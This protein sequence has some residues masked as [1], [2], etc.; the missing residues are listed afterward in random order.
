MNV[1]H[2][3]G[4]DPEVFPIFPVRFL[5]LSKRVTWSPGSSYPLS[6]CYSRLVVSESK[7]SFTN[8]SSHRCST[9]Q[10]NVNREERPSSGGTDVF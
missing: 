2:K 9:C 5:H 6:I 4:I 3:N 8:V 1:S 10:A 7:R